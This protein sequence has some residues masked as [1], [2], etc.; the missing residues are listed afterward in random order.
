MD[1]SP[2]V[3]LADSG[4]EISMLK[5]DHP[6][7]VANPD[8]I[9][10]VTI[11]PVTVDGKPI[12]MKGSLQVNLLIDSEVVPAVFHITSDLSMPSILGLNVMRT[13]D[14]VKIDF[15]KGRGVVTFG[16]KRSTTDTERRLEPPVIRRISQSMK[17]ILHSSSQIPAR[18]EVILQGRLVTED[19]EALGSL[20][21]TEVIVEPKGQLGEDCIC[22]RVVVCP[23][24]GKVPL[25]VCNPFDKEIYLNQG[26]LVGSAE[27]LPHQP[28]VAVISEDEDVALMTGETTRDGDYR[29]QL[30]KMSRAAEVSE[31]ERKLVENFLL[32]YKDVFSLE[33]ELGHYAGQ[34]FSIHTGDAKPIRQMPR[35]I[36]Y[37]RKSE[38]DRQLDEMLSKKLI[39]PCESEWASPILL[40]KK[41][42]G[43][44]RFCIDYRR[45]NDV[46]KHDAF[47]L[48]NINDCLA[49]LGGHC[50]FFST[51][52]MASGYW[53]L[54][55]DE[56]SQE[57][58]AFTT[59]RGLFKPLVQPFGAK[60][61]VAHFSCDM[62][63]AFILWVLGIIF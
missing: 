63:L 50:E 19:S 39:E 37:H 42:D 51:L 17:V 32:K 48:P 25:R 23:K 34:K 40:V 6:S 54:T 8:R 31:E 45:L 47:P 20:E 53:Q 1:G 59:H 57:K 46:T 38:V 35:K 16:K 60:G 36:P 10:P 18:Q 13:R 12:P 62:C 49:S 24:L 58:A 56:E 5:E 61:G 29:E 30:L 22:A 15:I 21:G 44:L 55:M 52:D 41:S 4:A 11:Q 2:T 3:F 28:V 9:Q 7:V 33:G 27:V 14:H 43:S 26:M